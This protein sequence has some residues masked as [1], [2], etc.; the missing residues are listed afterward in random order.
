MNDN[1]NSWSHWLTM[2]LMVAAAFTIGMLFSEVRYLRAGASLTGNPTAGVGAGNLGAGA[3]NAPSQPIGNPE[4][5]E[6]VGENEFI[7]G[8]KNAQITLIEYSDFECPFC[9]RFHPTMQ[10]VLEKY[11]DD[12]RWVYRHYPLSFH[13]NAQKAAE[14]SECVAEQLGNDGFWAYAD[15]IVEEQNKLGGSLSPAAIL[16]AANA[17]GANEASFKTCLDS[18][19]YAQAVADDLA[20]GTA[21]GVTGT[22]GTILLTQD[23]KA[24][25]ISGALPIEQVKTVIDKYLQ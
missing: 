25:L 22:P 14:A 4:D 21:A 5:V 24:E 17:A 6:P 12:V 9:A 10:Q 11:G 3:E 1:N 19:K 2:A 18:G 16:A 8:N 23:G 20:S 13:P 7:R 15:A